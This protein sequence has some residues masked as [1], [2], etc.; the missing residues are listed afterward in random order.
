[1][2]DDDIASTCILEHLRLDASREIT[3]VFQGTAFY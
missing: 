1:M 3:F 2:R